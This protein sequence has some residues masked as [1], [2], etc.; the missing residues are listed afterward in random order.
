[1]VCQ[2][3]HVMGCC[4]SG[5]LVQRPEDVSEPGCGFS[6]VKVK[7]LTF[8]EGGKMSC[9]LRSRLHYLVA[10]RKDL[11]FKTLLAVSP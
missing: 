3:S 8:R 5:V 7:V 9:S 4:N 10:A 11:Y 6:G 1:M 2:N